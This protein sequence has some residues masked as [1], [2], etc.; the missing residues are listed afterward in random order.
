M[1]EELQSTLKDYIQ[2][3]QVL[4]YLAA[5]VSGFFLSFVPRVYSLI[6]VT[7]GYIGSTDTNR[8]RAF[9]LSLTYVLGISAM[10]LGACRTWL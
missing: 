3:G 9:M 1:L 4:S 5:F 2:T 6:P 7:L 8:H 10:G